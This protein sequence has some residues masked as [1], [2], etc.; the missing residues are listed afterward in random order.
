M[1]GINIEKWVII[2]I[3]RQSDDLNEQHSYY[4]CQSIDYRFHWLSSK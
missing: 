2:S 4:K 3:L 1:E